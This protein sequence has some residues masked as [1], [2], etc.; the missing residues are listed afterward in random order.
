MNFWEYINESPLHFWENYIEPGYVS[1]QS[2]AE[3]PLSIYAY[4]RKTVCEQK[5]DGVTTK[6]RGIIV[7]NLTGE[8]VA[9][10]FEKFHNY[11]T[12][13][14][15]G[16]EVGLGEP[17]V[18]EKMDG[19]MCT[20]YTWG[21]VDYIASKG[22]FHSIHAKWASAW[23]RQ[24]F[25][26]SLGVPAGN[27]AVFEGLHPDLRIVVDYADR[28]ELVLLTVI[29]NETGREYAPHALR[30]FARAKGL[31]LPVEFNLTLENARIYT[32]GEDHG[33]S[34]EGYVLTWYLDGKPPFRLK[35][36]FIEYLRLHRMVTGVSPKR[37]WEV[38]A[39]NQTP[40]LDEYLKQS[41]PWFSA[42]V[43]KWMKA[44]TLE[45]DRIKSE[46]ITRFAAAFINAKDYV[47][48]LG[49]ADFTGLRKAYAAKFLTPENK[50]FQAVLF[51]LLDEKDVRPIIWKMVKHM[52]HGHDPMVDAHNT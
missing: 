24:H 2:H 43:Q 36:K 31:A 22:S 47:N 34:E 32:M 8:I 20:L 40:E 16:V 14:D 12:G 41:T 39:G 3:F 26:T 10:P 35:L 18:W 42:F 6:C 29:E 46:S 44:L 48:D 51:A 21:G 17:T 50:E 49:Y 38:L 27:T 45:H 13:S 4:G 28:K 11:G 1:I 52:T 5:W 30:D 33:A 9:R 37:I 15:A 7:N 25:G 19:F 23:L